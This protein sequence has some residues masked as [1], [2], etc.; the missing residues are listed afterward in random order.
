MSF[1]L[2][3]SF[4]ILMSFEMCSSSLRVNIQGYEI[5][6]LVENFLHILIFFSKCLAFSKY[7]KYA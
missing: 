4:A 3:F 1:A 5:E 6:G 7:L 2:V